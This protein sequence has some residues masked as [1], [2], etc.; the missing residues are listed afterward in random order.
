MSSFTG[1]AIVGS[2]LL[3]LLSDRYGRRA[4]IFLGSILACVGCALQGGANT[5]ATIIV[6]R[7]IAGL[8]VGLLS[9]TIPNY[10]SEIAHP[11]FRALLAGLQQWSI[12]LG[13]VVAQ[14]VGY[15]SSLVAGPFSWRFP[16][17]L[18]VLPATVLAAGIMF[19]PES[20]RYLAECGDT[21]TALAVLKRLH[22]DPELVDAEYARILELLGEERQLS[23]GWLDM[24][25]QPSLRKRLLLACGIQLFTQTSGV[26]VI[27]YYGPRI[28]AILNFDT[29][30]SLLIMGIA[31]ALAQL[32]NTVCLAFVDKIKRRTLLIPSMLGMG[33][34]L[35]V[36]AT[37]AEF[38]IARDQQTGHHDGNALR[39]SVAMNFVFSVFFT[40]LGCISWVF[41]SELFPTALRAKG[42]SLSTFTNWS[43]N[44]IF[45]Q[46]SPLAL[47][48]IGYRYF[49]V[50]MAFN[51]AAAAT[52]YF[53]FPETR[54]Y[55]LEAVNELFG[56]LHMRHVP[57]LPEVAAPSTVY[58]KQQM[59]EAGPGSQMPYIWEAQNVA[60]GKCSIPDPKRDPA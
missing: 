43:A 12:G 17:S 46:C 55:T 39:A 38:F 42:T 37:L 60:P 35:C 10:C 32:Y 49:Y 53:F 54:G 57:E 56:D 58:P 7:A 11:R 13:F 41:S 18:Q 24:F 33:A 20:P 51:W 47:S 34:A 36:N 59:A 1:G 26:N 31:G 4:A 8:A 25:R 44:L 19:L 15:A 48:K 52:V 5:V 22:T 3:N 29:T 27:S 40:S 50:F 45:A 6:G 23:M 9:A 16:L 21:A 2:L 30:R 14:W 28:Y